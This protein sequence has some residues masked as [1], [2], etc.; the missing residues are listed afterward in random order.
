MGVDPIS[1]GLMATSVGLSVAGGI[2]QAEAAEQKAAADAAAYRYRAQVAENNAKIAEENAR[3]ET[4]AGEAATEQAGLRSRARVG[5]IKAA[6]A[7]S[8]VDVN[9]GSAA[10][11]SDAAA[12]LGLLD[13]MTI[14]SNT[15]RKAYGYEVEAT[16]QRANAQL[17]QMS[18]TQAEVA[19]DYAVTG[20]LLGTAASVTGKLST[21][22]SKGGNILPT[23]GSNAPADVFGAMRPEDI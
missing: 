9:T 16:S 21:W 14:R 12:E 22:N 15:A 6:Q 17:G 18:A 1:A 11:I 20:S 7:A 19:G 8:G 13:A 4:A 23:G 2:N 3:L 10:A 5:S